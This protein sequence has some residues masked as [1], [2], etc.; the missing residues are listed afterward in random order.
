MKKAMWRFLSCITVLGVCLLLATAL[1]ASTMNTV[2]DA[3]LRDSPS[4][5]GKPVE[6]LSSGTSIE[7]MSEEGDWAKVQA[8]GKQGWLPTSALR[9]RVLSLKEGTTRIGT[10]AQ[11]SEVALSGKGFTQQDEARMGAEIPNM[12]FASVDKMESFVVSREDRVAFLQ[13]GREGGAQ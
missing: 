11:K 6:T 13:A 12:D 8:G 2:K 5:L 3:V 7:L 1:P 10:G 4:M 9:A